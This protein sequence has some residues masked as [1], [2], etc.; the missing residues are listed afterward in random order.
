MRSSPFRLLLV[1]ALVL[2]V[3]LGAWWNV[4]LH[5]EQQFSFLARSFIHGEL[6]F[7]ESPGSWADTSLY[8]GRHYWPLGPLPALI[9]TPFVGIADAF[10]GFFYQGYLQPLLV[11]MV[12]ALVWRIARREGYGR[13]DAAWL[14]FGFTFA[15]A[16]LGVAMW[17]WGWYFAQVVTTALLFTAIAETTGQRRSWIIGTLFA[18]TLATRATAAIGILWPIGETLLSKSAW[19]V[20]LV[21]LV[22]LAVPCLLVLCA[23][24]LYNDARFGNPF[25]QGYAFQL[26]PAHAVAA[27]SYGIMSPVHVPGNLYYLLVSGP[28]PVL[29]DQTSNV[30][31]PPFVA[32][33]PWGMSLFVTS[34]CFLWLVGLRLKDATTRVILVTIAAIAV[35]IVFYYGVGF[36]QFGYRYS[37]D[38]LPFLYLLLMRH[39]RLQGE[40]G[41]GFKALLLGSASFNLYL[42]A[43]HFLPLGRS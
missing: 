22:G 42:F 35:P 3:G 9:L 30:L 21:A 23:L 11:L 14:A 4:T 33:N 43:G 41:A 1:A 31:A 5:S 24:L 20:R 6:A 25:E 27:R 12:L 8:E 40:L 36:R 10:G 15:T 7:T 39:R 2:F 13:E 19:R 34:P 26:I 18:L 37:L 38:F 16:F 17:P 28:L 32:L 29:R